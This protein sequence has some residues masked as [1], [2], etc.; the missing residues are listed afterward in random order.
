MQLKI[1]PSQV[2]AMEEGDWHNICPDPSFAYS[3]LRNY[4]QLLGLPVEETLKEYGEVN[5]KPTSLHSV[6]TVGA[7][8]NVQPKHLHLPRFW[9]WAIVVAVLLV[10]GWQVFAQWDI[11]GA[12]MPSEITETSIMNLPTPDPSSTTAGERNE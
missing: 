12:F 6:N 7:N 4:I 9:R 5:E 2:I 11:L 1:R 3:Y 10:I 8:L